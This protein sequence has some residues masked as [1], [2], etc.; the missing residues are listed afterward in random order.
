MARNRMTWLRRIWRKISGELR[1]FIPGVGIK[2]WILAI[3]A[4]ITLLAIG[5]AYLLL[6][7]YR[8]APE[9]WWL[10]AISAV[11]LR[12]LDRPLRVLI[13]GGLG[14]GLVVWGFYGLNH[15]LLKPFV[16]PGSHVLDTV[17][18]YR[19]RERGPR[20]VVIG[21]GTGL[22]TLLRGLKNHTNNLTAIVTVADDGGSSGELRKSIGILPPGDIRSCLTALSDDEE[23][24]SQVFQY[25]FGEG[26]GL[27]G[28]SF[29]NLFITAL[30]EI[31][32]SFEEAVA[33]SGRVL[34]TRGRVLP[35]TL[36]D[37][38]LAADIEDGDAQKAIHVKGE[39]QIPRAHG[40]IRRIW[41]E[42]DNPLAFPPAIQSLL[43][44]DLILIGP[45]SL[46]TSILPNLLVPDLAQAVRMSRAMKFYIC[47]VATQTG[48]T[49]GFSAL[50]HVKTI[51]KHIGENIFDLILC[52]NN[53]SP[54]L[55][56][57][58]FWVEADDELKNQYAVYTSDQID[59]QI[60]WRHHSGK[61][62][63]SVMDLYLERTGPLINKE[64]V[65]TNSYN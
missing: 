4:G 43:A 29:G 38:R 27:N 40:Q 37:V 28:H 33:E 57:N 35:A 65:E 18:A 17:T 24:L 34:A 3:L 53:T 42:P 31:T 8:T 36:H 59:P 14:V 11:A 64:T 54:K 13:Y 39:S 48:E 9:T 61:L 58:S 1:W 15:A 63:Q 30:T 25:R 2:R 62:A 5:L 55:P 50:K 19:R 49:E 6:D 44:A 32:G 47:N 60:P 51:E 52:N 20:I 23:L 16:K 41:L 21:G 56:E 10:P 7:I 22:S 45:G 26:A 12:F 46:Y